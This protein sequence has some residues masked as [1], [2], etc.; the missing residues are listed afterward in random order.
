MS[1]ES[2][3]S[4]LDMLAKR[5]MAASARDGFT[6]EQI[7]ETLLSEGNLFRYSK[8]GD[9]APAMVAKGQAISDLKHIGVEVELVA[10]RN[11]VKM[12]SLAKVLGGEDKAKDALARSV[13]EHTST[14][15][16]RWAAQML[17]GGGG[18][19]HRENDDA[20]YDGSSVKAMLD[21]MRR[22]KFEKI[23]GKMDFTAPQVITKLRTKGA[24]TLVRGQ[25]D[26][27]SVTD[28]SM[29]DLIDDKL[30]IKPADTVD[31][32][33]AY[34]EKDILD[35]ARAITSREW[36]A[37]LDSRKITASAA[38]ALQ[39]AQT[40]RLVNIG[41]LKSEPSLRKP[42]LLSFKSNE[43]QDAMHALGI[44]PNRDSG[45]LFVN[46]ETLMAKLKENPKAFH[47]ILAEPAELTPRDV[48]EAL[49]DK[50]LLY[51]ISYRETPAGT[52]HEM[53]VRS[54]DAVQALESVGINVDF[55]PNGGR[56]IQ[57]E[58]ILKAFGGSDSALNKAFSHADLHLR[59]QSAT[60]ISR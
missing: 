35:A 6:P 42:P 43:M 30:K 12:D 54:E 13:P 59:S 7:V 33:P 38:D 9:E 4:A 45:N 23:N 24:L 50:H 10:G 48:V 1:E 15:S 55:R 14:Q 8:P 27:Y 11:Y 44:A 19:K 58:S 17:T 28:N 32:R 18:G 47:S 40:D 60:D 39:R 57:R 31:G 29:Q 46:E 20:S 16:V 21:E 53:R 36:T 34:L 22:Q 3:P 52:P 41:Y 25:Q 51:R 37:M 2:A 49:V 5:R 26:F 56:V